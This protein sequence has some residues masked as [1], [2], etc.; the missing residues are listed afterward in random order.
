MFN[1]D[2]TGFIY[3]KGKLGSFVAFFLARIKRKTLIF[4]DTEDEALLHKEELEYFSGKDVYIFPPYSDKVF[5]KE[6]EIKRTAFLSHLISDTLFYGLFPLSALSH[7]LTSPGAVEGMKMELKFGDVLFR[8]DLVAY[9]NEK[10]YEL[11]SLVREEGEYAKRGSIIDVFAPSY[12]KPVRIEFLGDEILSL[13]FFDPVSQRSHGEMDGCSLVPVKTGGSLDATV[14]DYM[15]DHMVLVHKGLS[16][17]LEE[18]DPELDDGVRQRVRQRALTSLNIDVSGIE[19]LEEGTILEAVSNEDLRLLFDARKTEVFKTLSEKFRQDWS[20]VPYMYVFANTMHQGERLCEIFRNY[21]IPLP[22]L[23]KMSLSSKDGERGIVVG[24]LRRG[25][26]TG[27]IIVLTEEDIVGPKKRV[28]RARKDSG[29]D[30]F[31]TSFKDLQVGEWVVHVDHGIG[32]YKG[33]FELQIGGHT[34]DFLLVEYQDGDKLYVPIDDL[35]LVQKFI[36]GE[37]FKPKIDKLGSQYWKST[38]RK[39]RKQVEDIADDLLKIYAEREMAEGY[40]YP[41]EDE[42]FREMESRF[43]YE[44]TEGQSE[45]IEAVLS[46]LRSTKPMDRVICGDVGFGK[47]EVALRAAFKVVLENKQVALLVPTTILAQQHFKTFQGR[48]GDYPIRI[49]MLSRFRSR[50]EQ[51]KIIEDVKKGTVDIIIGTHRLLQKDLAFRDLGLLIV[52]EEQRFGVKHKEHLKLLATN[53]DILTLSATPIPRT[54]YM[55]TMGIKDLSIINT[56]PLDRLAVKTRVVKFKDDLIIKAVTEELA[57]EGQIFFVHN[58]I[59]NIGVVYDHLTKLVPHARIA[60]AHGQMDGKTLEKIML[61]FIDRKYDILLSTNIIESGLDISNVNTIFINNAHRMGLSELYQLRGRVG[62]STRQ[63][64]AYLLVPKEEILRKDSLLRL[65]IIEELSELGSGFHVAN[66]DL[67]IRGAGNLLGKEQSGNVNLIGFELY[68][69]MLEEAIN[70][71]R[72]DG[73][74]KEAEVAPEINLPV[75]AYIPDT[76]IEDPAQKLLTYKRLSKIRDQEELTDMENEL[77]DRYGEIP[78]PLVSLLEIISLKSLLRRLKIKKLDYAAKRLTLNVTDRTPV[79]MDNLLRLV[80]K[81]KEKVKLLP[82]GRII[83]ST[84]KSGEELMVFTR[85]ILKQIVSL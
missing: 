52:D 44:E 59:H 26:R 46:D 56:P 18:Y 23:N 55:A 82:D 42:L 47:T 65:K 33:I 75:D 68:C 19:G 21:D 2:K 58:F 31:L 25:F 29:I 49:E 48:F 69:Q 60:V 74:P 27:E 70:E 64:Y 62:R 43:D 84:D 54:L 61:D 32:V 37:K 15:E 83:M 80:K 5:E 72:S 77:R 4:Y 1:P 85:N 63:A 3:L 41:P 73:A 7:P 28:A 10:G 35:H 17:L 71:L 11:T 57:R 50:E 66:Y 8:E 13:R 30:E 16:S 79:Q 6:D 20:R 78:A 14:I 22:V 9:L 67:E 34:K 36:G 81:E 45:A 38:T 24:P 51:K 40:A 76:Y 53:I 39:V 12:A